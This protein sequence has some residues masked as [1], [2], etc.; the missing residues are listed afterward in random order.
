M[1]Y[2]L[3]LGLLLI[4]GCTSND[5]QLVQTKLEVVVPDDK[6]YNCP[7]LKKFPKADTLTDIQVSQTILELYK[8]N[9]TCKNSLESIKQY[10]DQAKT[11]LENNP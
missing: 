1:K 6:L 3:F 9:V 2:I 8:N 10:L 5:P 4:A 11:R 7:T